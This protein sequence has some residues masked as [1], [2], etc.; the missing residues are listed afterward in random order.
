[1]KDSNQAPIKST[2]AQDLPLVVDLD[3]TLVKTDLFLESL[4]GL[5]KKN[6]LY[7]FLCLFWLA[8]GRAYLKREI[9]RRV[10]LDVDFLPYHGAVVDYLKT[11]YAQGRRL[12]LGTG[13]DRLHACQVAEDLA[14]F[15]SVL[16]SDGT[17]NLT[18]DNK[19]NRLL[20]CFGD[21]GFDY[22]GNDRKDLAVWG[23]ARRAIAV[24]VTSAV[25]N[26]LAQ[27][28]EIA[29]V[30]GP[31]RRELLPC[32]HSLRPQQ[33]LKNI[34]VF[35]PL[36]AA[37]RGFEMLS[38]IQASGAFLAFALS[39]SS[40]YVLNELL[41][42]SADRRHPRKR[43]RPL[44]GGTLSVQTALTLV[45]V[46]VAASVILGLMLPL[47]F[48]LVLALYY[49]LTLAYSLCLKHVAVLDVILLAALYGLRIIA[50]SWALGISPSSWLLVFSTFLFLS[51]A[52]L[53]RYAELVMVRE[54]DGE[55]AAAR[56]Y[57]V[58]DRELLAALGSAS[59]YG[60]VLVLLLYVAH[61]ST[62]ILYED[63]EFIF[64]ICPLLLYWIS[65]VWLAAHRGQMDDDPLIFAFRDRT[66]LILLFCGITIVLIAA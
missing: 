3:G 36:L 10:P 56:G 47:A 22:A 27:L 32:I 7:L 64:V 57:R 28:T 9:A 17:T 21:K 23:A 43:N 38:L 16:A 4:F 42:L 44:A 33:W 34:L 2:A 11:E 14:I 26:R 52:L 25:E 20:Q 51:L 13:S 40:F 53:K 63:P 12:I 39:A 41:N 6:P 59:G 31:H 66:S 65:H 29:K 55:S 50:G 49:G 5:L 60:S 19:K 1:M 15:E 35:V 18:A 37:H 24:N 62:R 46:L 30:F 48:L 61:D 45:P 8:K 58:S 54:L